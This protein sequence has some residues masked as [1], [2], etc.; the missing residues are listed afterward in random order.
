VL[1]LA[2]GCGA[3]G[4][5]GDGSK[6]DTAKPDPDET[7]DTPPK[8]SG[9]VRTPVAPGKLQVAGGDPGNVTLR[10]LNR[11][12]YANTLYDLLGVRSE[13]AR[14]FPSDDVGHGFDNIADVLT[15]SPLLT[16]M[17]GKAANEVISKVFAQ[18]TA[19]PQVQHVE[20]ETLVGTV[21]AALEDFWLLFSNGTIEHSPTVPAQGLYEVRVRAFCDQGGAEGCEMSLDV[22]GLAAET[23]T[24]TAVQSAPA[25]HS[26]QVELKG[27]VHSIGASFLNDFYDAIAGVDRN[28]LVDWIEVEGPLGVEPGPNPLT[29]RLL[30]CDPVTI[31]ESECARH[32]L[33]E[34]TPRAW[35]RP[36]V[37]SE[38]DKLMDLYQVARAEDGDFLAGLGLALEGVL[39]SPHFLFRVE[40]Q[41]DPSPGD[42]VLLSPHELATRLSYFLWSTLPD[43]ELRAAADDS[44][45]LEAATLMAQ[46]RRMLA[47]EKSRALVDNFASQW[48]FLRE[49]D[50]HQAEYALFPAFDETLKGAMRKETELMFARA[51]DGTL[52]VEQL[53]TSDYTLANDR[54]RA[55]Y[56]IGGGTAEFAKVSLAG[57]NR[58]GLLGQAA[59]QTLTSY[60][61]R[62]SPVKRGKFILEQLLCSPPPPPPPGVEGL[63]SEAMPTG[64]LRQRLEAHRAEPTCAGCHQLMDPLGFALENF[65]AIGAYRSDDSG[66][67]PID[68]SGTLTDGTQVSGVADLAQAL[69]NDPR[70]A[71]CVTEKLFVYAL[72]RGVTEKDTDY[73]D[74][75]SEQLA[76][77]AFSLPDL[78]VELVQSDTFRMRSSETAGGKQ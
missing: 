14:E 62:T 71:R 36:T 19:T 53:L 43:P 2:L 9:P 73:V 31:G 23:V 67:F 58:T 17:Y 27:G 35:R 33:E 60:P 34:F 38:I 74:L 47:D 24:V 72:G 7:V 11:T 21:G 52:S 30:T 46:V 77:S 55:F 4:S 26:V 50:E 29:A 25:V 10:R 1:L 48:L 57:T 56:G 16:E 28:L 59:I 69:K 13:T 39:M 8:D 66:G 40:L 6:A 68:A 41:A 12:E 78:L 65:D 32:V 45:L 44:S 20:A 22:D 76:Q 51:L 61:A 75:L 18:S 64:T 15:M 5:E 37:D 49:F 54:L 70:Y 3:S 63:A 42:I